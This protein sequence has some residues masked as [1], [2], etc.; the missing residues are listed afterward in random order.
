MAV[1]L[2]TENFDLRVRIN[3]LENLLKKHN[4]AIPLGNPKLY[5]Q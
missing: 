4:I 3:D 2:Q 1:N 5:S